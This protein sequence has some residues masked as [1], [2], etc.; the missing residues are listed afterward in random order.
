MNFFCVYTKMVN[1]YSYF[2]NNFYINLQKCFINFI[3]KKKKK[4]KRSFKKQHVKGTEIF[5]KKKKK[6]KNQS[7][8]YQNKNF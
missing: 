1:K 2:L 3:K 7:H 6:K 4:K 8:Q 5:Q